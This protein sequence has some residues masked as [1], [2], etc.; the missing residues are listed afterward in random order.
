MARRAR[1]RGTRGPP[2]HG[3]GRPVHHPPLYSV[4]FDFDFALR[5]A[6]FALSAFLVGWLSE[7]R[8]RTEETL[9]LA[10]D[11]LELRVQ[12][13]M[14]DLTRS[15]ERLAAEIA[16]RARVEETLREQAEL[17][18]LTHDTIFVRDEQDV[19]I[20]WNRGA[21][22]MYG[23]TQAEAVG[24]VAHRRLQTVFPHAPRRHGRAG[25]H[26][27]LGRRARPHPA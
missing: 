26:R 12:A 25:P 6:V 21:E 1:P 2:L 23:W 4:S 18:D 13:R 11:E 20:Y 17:L 16:A 27:A 5:I 14:A 9:R 22:E 3:G 15:N 19:I 10:R 7:W 8:R 24:A